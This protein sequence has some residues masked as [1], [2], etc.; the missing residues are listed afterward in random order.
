MKRTIASVSILIM[1]LTACASPFWGEKDDQERGVKVRT[2]PLND[3]ELVDRLGEYSLSGVEEPRGVAV[4]FDDLSF[5]PGK[6][7]LSHQDRK[8]FRNLAKVLKDPLVID[9]PIAVEG[10]TDSIGKAVYNLDLSKRRAQAVAQ[11][12]IFNQIRAA[13]ITVRGYGEQF[14]IQANTHPDG[15]DNPTARAQNRRVEVI[16]GSSEEMIPERQPK[17]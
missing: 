1:L 4:R 8:T 15:T 6:A 17:R 9:R 7:G 13:R 11:E 12:L 3:D 16:I 10:H 14:P 2:A 5:A